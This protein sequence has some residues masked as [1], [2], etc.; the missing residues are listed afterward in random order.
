M[1]EPLRVVRSIAAPLMRDNVDTDLMIRVERL[2]GAVPR[3]QLGDYAFETLRGP[4][5]KADP[6]FP[7]DVA[8]YRGAQILLAGANFGCGSAREGAVWA[9]VGLGVRVI[10]APSFADI[11]TTNCFQN[12]LLPVVLPRE[13]VEQLATLSGADAAP[14]PMTIDLEAQTVTGPDGSIDRFAIPALRRRGLLEG[15]EEIALTLTFADDIA[16][17]DRHDQARRPWAYP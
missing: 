4:V 7:F 1:P 11:F 15:L 9:L 16:R 8:R 6:P 14:A 17:F 13:R 5:N 3:D 10:V 12:G 2:F